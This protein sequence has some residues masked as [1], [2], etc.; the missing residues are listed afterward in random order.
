MVNIFWSEIVLT[1]AKEQCINGHCVN[2]KEYSA[3]EVSGD[4][5]NDGG[6]VVVMKSFAFRHFVHKV[7]L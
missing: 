2:I 7:P 6:N 4:A 1:E 3:D 5:E